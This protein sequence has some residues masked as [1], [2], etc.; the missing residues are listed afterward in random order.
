MST[1]QSDDIPYL[2]FPAYSINIHNQ[3]DNMASSTPTSQIETDFKDEV[4]LTIFDDGLFLSL[5]TE[6]EIDAVAAE[7]NQQ[8]VAEGILRA[9]NFSSFNHLPSS[10]MAASNDCPIPSTIT[11]SSSSASYTSSSS[12]SSDIQKINEEQKHQQHENRILQPQSHSISP[13]PHNQ[14]RNVV[15]PT[16]RPQN[17]VSTEQNTSRLSIGMKRDYENDSTQSIGE[18]SS[19]KNITQAKK[20]TKLSVKQKADGRRERNRVHAKKSR[21]RKKNFVQ[22]L[23]QS[24]IQL[25]QENDYLRS[26]IVQHVDHITANNILNKRTVINSKASRG[27]NGATTTTTT[28][29]ISSTTS[30]SPISNNIIPLVHSSNSVAFNPQTFNNQSLLPNAS[31]DQRK[32]LPIEGEEKKFNIANPLLAMRD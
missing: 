6:E 4:S 8:L 16:S 10:S 14:Q 7:Q 32:A 9:D 21:L 25:K 26:S 12:T 3:E 22:S 28:T 23:Q 15:S 29:I 1:T 19:D 20:K 5:L 13:I 31:F 11:L 30:S 27:E 2:P 24:I 17:V 18:L